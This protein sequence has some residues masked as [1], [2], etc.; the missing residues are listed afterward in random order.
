MRE[1]LKQAKALKAIQGTS[2]MATGPS[3]TSTNTKTRL[4]QEENEQLRCILLSLGWFVS[5]L[6]LSTL[7]AGL[8][9]LWAVSDGLLLI[10]TT[11]LIR[12]L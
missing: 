4:V 8:L 2:R 11:D 9:L 10:A 1:Y 5:G 6:A 3:K 7:V 12:T